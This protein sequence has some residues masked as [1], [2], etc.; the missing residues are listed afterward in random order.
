[1]T[2]K[3]SV[4]IWWK[5]RQQEEEKKKL[6]LVCEATRRVNLRSLA[7]RERARRDP[8]V[9]RRPP[10]RGGGTGTV[11]CLVSSAGCPDVRN[12][13][14]SPNRAFKTFVFSYVRYILILKG[15]KNI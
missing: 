8:Q 6:M 4:F 13:L 11:A 10:V 3:S 14:N 12:C 5:I 2:N 7:G 15:N 1:M 9:E